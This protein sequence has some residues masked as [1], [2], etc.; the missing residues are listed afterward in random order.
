M[1]RK[2]KNRTK[3]SHVSPSQN[4]IKRIGSAA[5]EER[6]SGKY[7]TLALMGGAA[8]FALKGCHN[9]KGNNDGDGVYYSSQMDCIDDGNSAQQCRDAWDNARANFEQEIPRNM[10]QPSCAY[11]FGNCYYDT[12][13][14]RWVP[15]M[16]GFLLSKVARKESDERYI[17]TSSG[18]SYVSRPVWRDSHGDYSW[19]SGSKE[20]V[21]NHYGYTT[22]KAM[23]S[24]RGGYGRSSSARGSWGG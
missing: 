19:R 17:Y 1:A 16:A 18:S 21:K 3:N 20:S 7:L 12:V 8:F 11:Q 6:K 5:P 24:S 13:G 4:R 9:Q 2:K 22:K 10:T 14:Q 15:V 23:T